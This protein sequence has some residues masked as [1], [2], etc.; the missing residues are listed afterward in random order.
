MTGRVLPKEEIEAIF[1]RFPEG[2]PCYLPLLLAYECGLTKG[3]AFGLSMENVVGSLDA[4]PYEIIVDH[5]LTYNRKD[6]QHYIYPISRRRVKL[7]TIARKALQK[8]VNRHFSYPVTVNKYNSSYDLYEAYGVFILNLNS[9]G[10]LVS[11]QSINYIA[12][13]IHGKTSI[14]DYV[15]PDWK[16]EDMITSGIHYRKSQK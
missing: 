13:V 9:D 3:E 8:A 5:E 12:R 7:T 1:K 10:S 4:R 6:N 16:F 14:I 11:P 15:D 2:T